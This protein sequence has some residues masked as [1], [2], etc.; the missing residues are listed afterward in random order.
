MRAGEGVSS[1]SPSKASPRALAARLGASA[2][3]G[4][5]VSSSTSVFH[6]PQPAHWPAHFDWA[7]PGL[8]D[9]EGAVAGHPGS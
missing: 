9:V 4:R 6:A 5:L 7:E 3:G 8:A 1:S 2:P